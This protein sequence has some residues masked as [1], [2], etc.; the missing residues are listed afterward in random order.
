ME[1]VV[2]FHY[3]GLDFIWRSDKEQMNIKKHDQIDFKEAATVF[4]D[5]NALEEDDFSKTDEEAFIIVGMSKKFRML[6]V[7]Y[8]YREDEKIRIYS[9]RKASPFMQKKYQRGAYNE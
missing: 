9:A 4:L 2:E 1:D 8:C 3:Q 6:M 5:G 7:C